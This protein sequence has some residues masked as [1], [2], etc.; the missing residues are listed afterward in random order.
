MSLSENI[1]KYRK[2]MGYTQEKLGELLGVTNQAV[3]KWESSV[4]FPD[5][6]LLPKIADVLGIT[7]EELYG[8]EKTSPVER[9]RADSFPK[10]ANDHLIEYFVRQSGIRFVFTGSE[11]E[12][13]AY[14]K[15]KLYETTD[16]VLGCISDE[17]GA[18]FASGDISYINTDYKTAGSEN[19]FV[20]REI[21]SVLNRFSDPTVRQL[22]AYMYKESFSDKETN[23][24]RFL[25]TSVAK[26]CGLSEEDTFEAF[27]KLHTMKL[28]DTY[29]NNDHITEYYF[30]KSRAVFA[31][32][33][34]KLFEKMSMDFVFNVMR[35]TSTVDDYAF[36]KLWK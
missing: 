25:V 2:Q 27:E 31:F 3:S 26:D 4:S 14:H 15:K 12:N 8:I 11:E 9:V 1:S 29:V 35:D 20:K 17:A 32:T 6:M 13:L 18:V 21:A 30:L 28:L 19:I 22:L 5:V 23:N 10:A 16:C 24:K 34:F 7:L 36:E 33:A